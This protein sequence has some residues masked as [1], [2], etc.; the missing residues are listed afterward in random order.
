MGVDGGEVSLTKNGRTG[1][2]LFRPFSRSD[3][4]AS[5]TSRA[6]SHQYH[7]SGITSYDISTDFPPL[8]GEKGYVSPQVSTESLTRSHMKPAT[9]AARSDGVANLGRWK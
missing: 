8:H 7:R 2:L 6:P 1:G 5:C 9:T 4:P 3:V